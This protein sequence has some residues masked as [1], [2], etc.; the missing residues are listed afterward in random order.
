M[1]QRALVVGVSGIIGSAVAEHLGA[2][3]WQVHGLARRPAT[4]LPN[5]QPIAADLLDAPRL[6]EALA[7]LDVSHVFFTSWS[8]QATE[9]QNCEVN[10][11]MVRNLLHALRRAP[12]LSHVALVTGL[13]HYL[14][15]F[16][17]YGSQPH[18]TPFREEQERLPIPNFYY[19]QED[20]V[21]AAAKER[22]FTW[23][24]H[25]PHSIIGH[26]TGNAMNVGLTVAVYATLCRETGRPFLFPGSEIQW[27][28]LNDM[29]DAGL[30]A[31]H[32]EW[33]ATT[34][35]ARNEAYNVVN[36]DLFRWSWLWP[37][38]AGFFGVEPGYAGRQLS[39]VEEMKGIGP[40]WQEI[41]ARHGLVEPDISR[42][43]TW[44]HLDLNLGLPIECIADMS[45]SRLRGF[46]DYV[47]TP[48]ALYGL[49][50]RLGRERIIP[51]YE[52]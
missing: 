50:R 8:R 48:D 10:G 4:G 30:L 14:G 20:E 52:V 43:A 27:N 11:A 28:V 26:A 46:L 47:Y 40:I 19:V 33:A 36:G 25:R 37:R 5:V 41:A 1:T 44:W 31:R 45:K 39:M 13:K 9:A 24:V 42:L 32:L 49:F 38:I 18:P 23:S 51:S 34:E 15:P 22:G 35:Q 17:A 3:G 21:F 16:D 2:Q 29:T 6:E 7:G 12:S